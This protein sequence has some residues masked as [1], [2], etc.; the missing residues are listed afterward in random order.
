MSW[1]LVFSIVLFLVKGAS[2]FLLIL[3]NIWLFIAIVT[4]DRKFSLAYMQI[5]KRKIKPEFIL[6][7][8]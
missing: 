5:C 2:N 8:F 7:Y 6:L 4:I 1:L 3:K